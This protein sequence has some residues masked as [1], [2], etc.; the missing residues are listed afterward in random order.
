M[1]PRTPFRSVR[2]VRVPTRVSG[3]YAAKVL[4]DGYR[5]NHDAVADQ[6]ATVNKRPRL[7]R[8]GTIGGTDLAAIGR[9][10]RTLLGLR[11][12]GEARIPLPF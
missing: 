4:I 7:Q 8:L 3:L 9:A 6:I 10:I 12:I 1:M 11:G 2:L 5:E